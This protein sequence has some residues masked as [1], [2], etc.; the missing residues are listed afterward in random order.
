MLKQSDQSLWF[1][2]VIL[3][4]FGGCSALF[5]ALCQDGTAI[6]KDGFMQGYTWRVWLVVFTLATGGLMAAVVLRYADNILRQFSTAISILLTT[7]LSAVVLE[8][9]VLGTV[10]NA[11]KGMHMRAPEIPLTAH[12]KNILCLEGQL[13]EKCPLKANKSKDNERPKKCKT[14]QN[15]FG[16]EARQCAEKVQRI[17]DFIIGKVL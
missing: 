11:T 13:K 1:K 14:I 3:G 2:N 7:F 15:A 10:A 9:L 6:L 17:D 16:S 12:E 5:G 4:I 8:E